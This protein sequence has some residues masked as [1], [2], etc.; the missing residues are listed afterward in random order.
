MVT[1][2]GAYAVLA[3]I[4]QAA[5]QQFHWLAP[6]EMFGAL[7]AAVTLWATFAP[8]FLWIFLGAPFIETTR[9]Q[10]PFAAALATITASVVGVVLNLAVWLGLHTLFRSV[11]ET[12]LGPLHLPVPR[13][14]SL[15][16]FALALAVA[17]FVAM[18]RFKVGV[19][20]VVLASAAV[21]LAWK[22]AR[23]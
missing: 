5:V 16:L 2:G 21:G 18:R 17:A 19:L 20:P 9:H 7:G 15:D 23:G 22:L 11:D 14:A 13:I 12:T 1:F 10:K 8:C 3:Y 6:A 4:Q